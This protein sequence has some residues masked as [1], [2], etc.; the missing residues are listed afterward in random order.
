VP[1]PTDVAL[2]AARCLGALLILAAVAPAVARRPWGSRFIY[3][4]T[5]VVCLAFAALAP[6]TLMALPV[7]QLMIQLPVGLPLGRTLLGWD[8]LSAALAGLLNIVIA[9]VSIYAIG[10]GSHEQQPQ[11]V[12]PF[13]PAFVAGMNLVLLSNDAFSFLFGW[14]FM[15][16]ASWALVISQDRDEANRRAGFVYLTMALG[17]TL[18]LLL[19]FGLLAGPAGGYE[20]TQIRESGLTGAAAVALLILALVGTGSKAGLFPLHAWLPLAHPAAPSHVSA[21][22][23]GVMT[24]VAIYGFIRFAFD[25]TPPGQAGTVLGAL[26]IVLGTVT[27]VYAVLA[28]GFET[29]IK[30][31]LAYSTIENIG[32]IFAALGLTLAFQATALHAA[33]ALALTTALLHS[34]NH[35]FMKS[36]LFMGAGAV[37]AATGERHMDCF[38]GLARR[39]PRTMVVMLIGSMAIAA[40]PPLNGFVSEWL[41]FQTVLASPQVPGWMLKLFI[42]AAGAALALAAALAAATFIR[43]F[44]M[45]FLG[46]ARS[47]SAAEAHDPD[48]AS[49]AAMTI[50][51]A[52]CVVLGALPLLAIEPLQEVV[53]S[54][55][56]H[57]LPVEEGLPWRSLVPLPESASSYN[58]LIVLIFLTASAVLAALAL[59]F[60]ASGAMRRSAP[61]DCGHPDLRPVTQY[62]AVSFSEP[63][64][65][66]FGP[67]LFD[68][69][70]RVT[71][72]K[73]GDTVTARAEV[74][75]R[76]LPWEWGYARVGRWV[77]WAAQRLNTLQF[78]TIRRYLAMVF[79]AL[80]ILLLVIAVWR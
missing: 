51:A 54:L 64:K 67:A 32:F 39:M 15:S 49:I 19:V 74:T 65:R 8:S 62:S 18:T 1:H 35:A 42:P 43:L 12:L 20:F 80:V 46:R 70:T 58:G 11:R 30:R 4:A 44:G 27:A 23:S 61:W 40:L 59:R 13:Y 31:S 75:L 45:T 72:P 77:L 52:V 68:A 5:A 71:M 57:R 38:G 33:A 22:M 2:W 26:L 50:T 3:G 69:R 17:G 66:V 34:V 14:E 25:L 79:A 28:A 53:T 78:L 29:D 36:L 21:L 10:Y 73:P 76:D 9:I 16:L 41:L 63:I 7:Q 56:G 48:R 24:K 37:V 55:I 47:E 60:V 6:V